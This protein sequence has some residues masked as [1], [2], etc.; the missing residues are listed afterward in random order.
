MCRAPVSAVGGGRSSVGI[1]VAQQ[2]VKLSAVV[3]FR[4]L[5]CT[6]HGSHWESRKT[7]NGEKRGSAQGFSSTSPPFE[8]N[9]GTTISNWFLC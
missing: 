6:P 7:R 8:H 9:L 4:S 1:C 3:N 5:S 2:G